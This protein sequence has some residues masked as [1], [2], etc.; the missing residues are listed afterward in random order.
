MCKCSSTKFFSPAYFL[1]KKKKIWPLQ[2]M[3]HLS[4]SAVSNFIIFTFAIS[5]AEQFKKNWVEFKVE[6]AV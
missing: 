1:K 2:M 5:C 4:V 6:W 3:A